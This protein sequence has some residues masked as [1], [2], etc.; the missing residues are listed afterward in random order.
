MCFGKQMLNKQQAI[1]LAVR[2]KKHSGAPDTLQPFK[3]AVCGRWHVG[4]SEPTRRK[5]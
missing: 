4:K 1:Q 5:R 2:L 3:C